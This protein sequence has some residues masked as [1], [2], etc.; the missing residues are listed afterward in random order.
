VEGL[1]GGR[2]ALISKTHHCMIDG[3][4]GAELISV[5]LDLSPDAAVEPPPVWRPRPAPSGARLVADALL[6]RATQPLRALRAFGDALRE[7][8]GAAASVREAAAGVAEVLAPS[9]RSAS[10][11]PLNVASGPHRRYAM[12]EH[13]VADYKR[14]KDALGGTLND[15][16]LATVAGALREFFQ[17][18]GLETRGLEVRAMVPVSVRPKGGDGRLGNQITQ[19]VAELPVGLADPIERLKAVREIMRDL[20]ESRQALGGRVLTQISEWTV[21]NVLVQAVRLSVRSRPYNLVVTNVPGPQIPL[22]FLGAPMRASYPVAPLSP[23]QALNV[24]LFSYDRGL[25]WGLNADW[26]ALPDLE[27]LKRR[28]DDAFREL[29]HAAGVAVPP[30][31]P[32]SRPRA[33]RPPSKE[34][35]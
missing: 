30:A 4:A 21:P 7:P 15:V 6:A 33:R 14:V 22:Y 2:L 19:M 5:I 28:L 10:P 26:D 29:E 12:L 34:S 32:A 35:A 1:A 24:A 20:K 25:Y 11:T 16:V 18:R 23:G 13:R 3:V 9:F 8:L 27:E 31:P 17:D